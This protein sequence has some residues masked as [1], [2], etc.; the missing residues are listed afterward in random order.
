M[1]CVIYVIRPCLFITEN[2]HNL[3]Q[4]RTL[5]KFFFPCLKRADMVSQPLKARRNKI[6]SLMV[7]IAA[8]YKA[9]SALPLPGFKKK[10]I[11][12][13]M[14]AAIITKRSISSPTTTAH[15]DLFYI[16]KAPFIIR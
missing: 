13:L 5:I 16:S 3:L 8:Q 12:E 2:V 4:F 15:C 10:M 14:D 11:S 1:L 7:R 6:L 9:S